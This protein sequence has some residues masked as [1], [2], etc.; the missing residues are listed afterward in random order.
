MVNV[1]STHEV[2]VLMLEGLGFHFSAKTS[3]VSIGNYMG[4]SAIGNNCT[5]NKVINCMSDYNLCLLYSQ[6]AQEF[7]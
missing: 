2:L 1:C 5:C 4:S 3:G 6:V 7:M